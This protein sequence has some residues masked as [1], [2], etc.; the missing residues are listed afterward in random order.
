MATVA[1][2]IFGW[3]TRSIAAAVGWLEYM[4][5]ESALGPYYHAMFGVLVVTGFLL[6]PLVGRHF[7][8]GAS[9]KVS[10]RR[11]KRSFNDDYAETFPER[12]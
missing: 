9:D 6:G 10:R 7:S 12:H 5:R 4:M 2:Q 8:G 1:A 11:G 3:V